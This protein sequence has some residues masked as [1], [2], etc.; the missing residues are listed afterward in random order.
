MILN[1]SK[2]PVMYAIIDDKGKQYKV[3]VGE[4]V[5][6]DLMKAQVGDYVEFDRVLMVGGEGDETPRMGRP[7]VEGAR[8]LAE[9]LRH[10]KGPK[11]T[12]LRYNPTSKPSRAKKG[13]RQKYTRV[14]IREVLPE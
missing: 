2:D 12:M 13:H 4:E 8:V 9:V 7:Q 6:V 10:E 14:V 3:S 1:L 11:V 5:V